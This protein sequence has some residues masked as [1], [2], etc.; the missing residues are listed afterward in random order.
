MSIRIH[1]FCLGDMKNLV[2]IL[3]DIESAACA[4]VDPAWDVPLLIQTIES[5]QLRLDAILLTHGHFD[6]T[7][8]L[9]ELLRYRIVPIYMSEKECLQFRPKG[10]QIHYTTHKDIIML[11]K[12][13]LHIL[14]TPGHSPGGQCFYCA[15]HLITGDT[16]F[17][18]G[19]GRCDLTGSSLDDMFDSLQFIKQL[20]DETML[21]PGHNYGPTPTDSLSNQRQ[22]NRFLTTDDKAIFI[23]RRSGKRP[24]I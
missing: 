9:Q 15:P 6:H 20:P 22:T 21:Y 17:I 4:V 2:Y 3:H 16:V 18:D 13:P 23:R 14:H 11:G 1:T 8:G 19:C 7:Q 5:Y 10:Q 12:T 24:L